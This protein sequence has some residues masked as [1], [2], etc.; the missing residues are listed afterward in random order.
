MLIDFYSNSTPLLDYVNE[1][2]GG[3]EVVD[4]RGFGLVN[5]PIGL[6]EW[7]GRDL[8]VFMAEQGIDSEV[9]GFVVYDCRGNLI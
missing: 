6:K 5:I 9:H 4:K 8:E 1:K 7:F 3:R 2:Y